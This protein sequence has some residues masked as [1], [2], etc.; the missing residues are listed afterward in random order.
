[1]DGRR[2]QAQSKETLMCVCKRADDHTGR[3]KRKKGTERET[4]RD[5]AG[6]SA[7]GAGRERGVSEEHQAAEEAAGPGAG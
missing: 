6:D 4:G 1:M 2:R 3:R 5:G 7:H